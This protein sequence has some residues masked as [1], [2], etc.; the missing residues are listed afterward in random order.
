[1]S[2]AAAPAA[3]TPAAIAATPPSTPPTADG[4]QTIRANLQPADI[5][6]HPRF[7]PGRNTGMGGT[8]RFHSDVMLATAAMH[9]G[10]AVTESIRHED[11]LTDVAVQL[12]EKP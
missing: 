4:W 7:P 2:A 6:G 3:S 9:M 5:G 8:S 1:M 10:Y 11:T 12:I